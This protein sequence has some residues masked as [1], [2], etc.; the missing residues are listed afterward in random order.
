MCSGVPLYPVEMMRLSSTMSAPT[1]L[2]LQLA[3]RRTAIAM[4]M[5]YLWRSERASR[6]AFGSLGIIGISDVPATSCGVAGAAPECP[7]CFGIADIMPQKCRD[8]RICRP[9]EQSSAVAALPR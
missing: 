2:P 4:F 1:R 3:R 7:L 5:K 6:A 9:A 8:G